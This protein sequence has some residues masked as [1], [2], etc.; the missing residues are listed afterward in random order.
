MSEESGQ[1]S[2]GSGENRDAGPADGES[3][4]EPQYLTPQYLTPQF[5]PD[6]DKPTDP[7]TRP[8]SD[9]PT[10]P[11]PEA[12]SGMPAWPAQ[13]PSAASPPAQT[14]PSAPSGFTLPA[15][16]P[17]PEYATTESDSQAS[18][19][20][21][22]RAEEPPSSQGASYS[23]SSYS[24]PASPPPAPMPTSGAGG[25]YPPPTSGGPGSYAQPPSS[26]A[27]PAQASSPPGLGPASGVP[28][29]PYPPTQG[30]AAPGP[31][32]YARSAP[33]APGYPVSY[34]QLS[35]TT[36]GLAIGA[37]VTGIGS[38]VLSLLAC[39]FWPFAVLSGLAGIA[40]GVLG[41]LGMRQV[42]DSNGQ[43]AGKGMAI[44][45]IATGGAGLLLSILLA[46]LGV[47]WVASLY[48]SY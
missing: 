6:P 7:P 46:I 37:M 11:R 17:G 8:E 15:A 44:A 29:G 48:S 25:G 38:T 28:G 31:A 26:P 42:D 20:P 22:P 19:P 43:V 27:F 18:A 12:P 21:S 35:P 34:P 16:Q 1:R 39:C 36:S 13:G 23:L 10:P 41:F 9:Q 33:G 30:Y 45:G 2:D 5:V 3:R 32:Q 14:S 47:V 24:T 4:R 40:G